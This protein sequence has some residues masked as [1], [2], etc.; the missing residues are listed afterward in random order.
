MDAASSLARTEGNAPARPVSASGADMPLRAAA[1]RL[2]RYGKPQGGT[3]ALGI[4]LF[5]AGGAI[6][7]L[8]P[9][10][11]QR[12]IDSGFGAKGSAGF[13]VWIAPAAIIGLFTLRGLVNFCASYLF[14]RATSKVVLALRHDIVTSLLRADAD[15]YAHISPGVAANRVINDPHNAVTSIAGALTTLLRDGATLLGLMV[16]LFWLDWQLTLVSL[17][18]LPLLAFVVQRV[19]RRILAMAGRSYEAMVRLT[20]IVDDI[21]RAWRVVRSFDAAGFEQRRFGAEAERT[22]RRRT[23]PSLPAVGG[24]C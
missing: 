8:L 5:I 1:R 14:A 24:L 7:P 23:A 10:L 21:A 17:V 16:Y 3:L 19:Q 4:F 18:T 20:A 12:L 2:A 6:D 9:M 15:L 11:F 13:P 22:P